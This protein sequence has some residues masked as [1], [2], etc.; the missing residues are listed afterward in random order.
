VH[1]YDVHVRQMDLRDCKQLAYS[2]VRAAREAEC[3]NR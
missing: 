3:G 1:I 2:E